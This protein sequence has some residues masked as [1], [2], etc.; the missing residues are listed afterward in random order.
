MAKGKEQRTLLKGRE[1][2]SMYHYREYFFTKTKTGE[3]AWDSASYRSGEKLYDRDNAKHVF[4]KDNVDIVAYSN[5]YLPDGCPE[6]LRD[7]QTLWDEIMV[8]EKNKNAQWGHEYELS[9]SNELSFEQCKEITE[10]FIAE[11]LT[12]KGMICD[13]NIHW[14]E[15]NHHVHITTPTRPFD[16]EKDA[17]GAKSKKVD[18]KKISLVSDWYDRESLKERRK[19]WA[20]L[21]NE[22]LSPDKQVSEKSYKDQGIE[23]TP[24]R[25]LSRGDYE[26]LKDITNGKDISERHL[27]HPETLISILEDRRK[28][29]DTELIKL[30][31]GIKESQKDEKSQEDK[32]K[33]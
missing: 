16:L 24:R 18:G 30:Q 29:L 33:I 32:K 31:D 2:M 9:F 13:A 14:K 7:R 6:R 22:Y 15:G 23:K 17:F 4:R 25:F 12:K 11:Q 5:I 3:S 28:T 21:Q 8:A 19:M 1:L 27:S 10:R 20:D 26:A